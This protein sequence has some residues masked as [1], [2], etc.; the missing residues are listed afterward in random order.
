[1]LKQIR[2]I[3]LCF[4]DLSV[5]TNRHNNKLTNAFFKIAFQKFTPTPRSLKDPFSGSI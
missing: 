2:P 1:M 4:T 3:E 5:I